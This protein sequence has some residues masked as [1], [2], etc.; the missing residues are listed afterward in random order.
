[1]AD[2]HVAAQ[3]AAI[4]GAGA[5]SPAKSVPATDAPR[6]V[7]DR[8]SVLLTTLAV[9]TAQQRRLETAAHDRLLKRHADAAWAALSSQAKRLVGAAGEDAEDHAFVALALVINRL[10]ELR[11]T[12]AGVEFHGRLMADP[13]ELLG[14]FRH[15]RSHRSDLLMA[16][17]FCAIDR[18]SQLQAFG[19]RP[20]RPEPMAAAA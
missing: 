19:A 5:V 3:G 13:L 9:A 4:N 14:L 20:P 18:L 7:S 17:A 2:F 8:F 11:G 15:A 16:A 10:A 6:R 12:R 1:M